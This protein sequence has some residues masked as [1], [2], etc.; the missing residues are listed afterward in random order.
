MYWNCDN[1]QSSYSLQALRLM[2]EA[3]PWT[4]DDSAQL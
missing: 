4:L 2:A 3:G 1:M